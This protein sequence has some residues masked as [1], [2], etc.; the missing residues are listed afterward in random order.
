MSGQVFI[1]TEISYY[2]LAPADGRPA[3]DFGFDTKEEAEAAIDKLSG[4]LGDGARAVGVIKGRKE[5]G[6]RG[7]KP[8]T[9]NADKP[10]TENAGN[11]NGAPADKGPSAEARVPAL[12]AVS[13]TTSTK[14]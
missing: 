1:G 2:I 3:H 6:R 9:K 7:R 8:G 12:S 13:K 5:S 11:A 10:G 14:S 4:V